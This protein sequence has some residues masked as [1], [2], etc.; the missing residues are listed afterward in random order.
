M[1][2]LKENKKIISPGLLQKTIIKGENN[3]NDNNQEVKRLMIK[4]GKLE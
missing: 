1:T 3:D 4:I 2:I